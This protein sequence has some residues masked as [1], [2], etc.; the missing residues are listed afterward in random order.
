MVSASGY[1]SETLAW[2]AGVGDQI[3]EPEDRIGEVLANLRL[4]LLVA[5]EVGEREWPST[6]AR[7]LQPFGA[8]VAREI[9]VAREG[10]ADAA[11]LAAIE[12]AHR[13]RGVVRPDG[14]DR[15]VDHAEADLRAHRRAGCS[16]VP[17]R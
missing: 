6:S 16:P 14:V 15:L 1:F 13:I 7:Q 17:A 10:R 12:E 2:P 5:F 9:E 3:A 11:V 4:D 8:R